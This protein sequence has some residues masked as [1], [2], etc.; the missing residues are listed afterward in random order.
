MVRATAEGL[1]EGNAKDDRRTTDV[2]KAIEVPQEVAGDA[3]CSASP[4]PNAEFRVRH[5]LARWNLK[6]PE[7][8]Y[9]RY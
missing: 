4:A 7:N 8:S 6:I 1:L 2:K 5:E 3:A 9:Y